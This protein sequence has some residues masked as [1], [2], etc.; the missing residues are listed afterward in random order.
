MMRSEYITSFPLFCCTSAS[1]LRYVTV[2]AE[3]SAPQ[4]LQKVPPVL[5]GRL[6]DVLESLHSWQASQLLPD[7][8]FWRTSKLDCS[9]LCPSH[10]VLSDMLLELN[11]IFTLHLESIGHVMPLVS[12]LTSGESAQWGGSHLPTLHA[13]TERNLRS[14]CS[15]LIQVRLPAREC[16]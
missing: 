14:M 4:I 10:T 5:S 9:L 2:L 3:L 15:A 12:K 7:A 6:L 11:Y 1:T 16:R 8:Q 13:G